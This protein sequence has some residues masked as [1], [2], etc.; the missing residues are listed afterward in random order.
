MAHA[1]AAVGSRNTAGPTETRP[2]SNAAW[3]R[4]RTPVG[5]PADTRKRVA[6]RDAHVNA[7]SLAVHV[8]SGIRVPIEADASDI[9]WSNYNTSDL[10]GLVET[11]DEGLG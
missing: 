6:F 8:S 10:V 3:R 2:L 5:D 11:E 7:T 4:R 9:R 1:T